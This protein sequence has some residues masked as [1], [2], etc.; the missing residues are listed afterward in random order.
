MNIVYSHPRECFFFPTVS[1]LAILDSYSMRAF[2]STMVRVVIRYSH[3]WKYSVISSLSYIT[4]FVLSQFIQPIS[5]RL[6]SLEW[7]PR[8]I[9]MPRMLKDDSPNWLKALS[10][11]LHALFSHTFYRLGLRK[12]K[13]V[14]SFPGYFSS[15]IL[16][17]DFWKW[18][19]PI[20]FCSVSLNNPLA[21]WITVYLD[22][23]RLIHA[24]E[25]SAVPLH[26]SMTID[27]NNML[28]ILK[29]K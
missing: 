19:T 20:L 18:Y 1:S 16:H 24:N 13:S 11:F 3:S 14:L 10:G 2:S 8:D 26:I 17:W 5:Q 28:Y 22:F 12:V 23:K 9:S 29:I 7:I 21:F 25:N 27:N 15:A 6:G 4:L